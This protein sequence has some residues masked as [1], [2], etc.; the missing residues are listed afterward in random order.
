MYECKRG[1]KSWILDGGSPTSPSWFGC[2]LLERQKG[3]E[4]LGLRFGA[5]GDTNG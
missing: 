3:N 1:T 5:E 2:G 4:K